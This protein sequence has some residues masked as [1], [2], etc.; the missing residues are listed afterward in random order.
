MDMSPIQPIQYHQQPRVQEEAVSIGDWMFTLV[1]LT[2]PPVNIFF[3]FYWAFSDSTPPSKR[4]FFRA[5][6]ILCLIAIVFGLAL[7]L[8]F[9]GL[10]FLANHQH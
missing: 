1:V 10:A 3:V 7:F 2:M 6:L 5:F 4:N 9:S 8:L